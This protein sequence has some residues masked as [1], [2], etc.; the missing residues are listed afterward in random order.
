MFSLGAPI[1]WSAYPCNHPQ[2]YWENEK[3]EGC[4]KSF[5][6][7]RQCGKYF[8]WDGPKNIGKFYLC[9][10][11]FVF[12]ARYHCPLVIVS[13]H[14][15]RRHIYITFL[16]VDGCEYIQPF[17]KMSYMASS[18][19][20][21][22]LS[23]RTSFEGASRSNSA[24]IFEWHAHQALCAIRDERCMPAD[25]EGD[26]PTAVKRIAQW[27]VVQ[28]R[29][30]LIYLSNY[31]R[32]IVPFSVGEKGAARLSV[33]SETSKRDWRSCVWTTVRR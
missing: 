2:P 17:V 3:S 7:C 13:S 31:T 4:T 16:I 1:T 5:H 29:A 25:I 8:C 32:K 10:C 33:P 20:F 18:S 22:K 14:S 19:P 15:F 26:L 21:D 24:G 12:K 30:S 27:S 28:W 11:W 6:I 9:C 23:A